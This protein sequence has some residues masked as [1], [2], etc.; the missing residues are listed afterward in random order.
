MV[1]RIDVAKIR[2]R[3][4]LLGLS[5]SAL[6]KCM[7]V[8][9]DT[10]SSVLHGGVPSYTVMCKMAEALKFSPE[11]AALIFFTPNLRTA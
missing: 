1:Y 11:E 4:G 10:V 2:E 8:S 7:G 6:A 9:R 3:M 5:I